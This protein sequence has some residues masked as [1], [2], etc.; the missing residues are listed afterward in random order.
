MASQIVDGQIH[1]P[2]NISAD[3]PSINLKGFQW[4]TVDEIHPTP[5]PPAPSQHADR[6]PDAPSIT[7]ETNGAT[8]GTATAATPI[9]D[10]TV[11]AGQFEL[12]PGVITAPLA[13]FPL[14]HFQGVYA[15]NGFNTIFR[16]Q[17]GE[18]LGD[19][20]LQLNLTTEQ[21]TFGATIGSIPNRGLFG[22]PDITLQGLPYLQTIQDVT[23]EKTGKGDSITR[24][25]I[26]FETGVWLHVPGSRDTNNASSVVRMASI[27][28]GSTINAQSLA[29]S[30]SDQGTS[31]GLT[32][33]RPSF[34]TVNIT[35]FGGPDPKAPG[36]LQV[37]PSQTAGNS[38]TNRIPQDLGLFI[39][40]GTITDEILQ[41]PNKILETA[42]TGLNI[43]EFVTFEVSTGS[44]LNGGGTANVSFLQANANVPLVK[45]RFWI[46][47]I[48]YAVNIPAFTKPNPVTLRPT[49][50]A[51]STAP[52]PQF[53]ITPP[54]KLPSQ[55]TTILVPGTQIQY[56]QV[57]NL[58]F[59]GLTWPHASVAT[60]VPQAPQ[61]FT[62]R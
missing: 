23:N 47:T 56:S 50:P 48:L 60:L 46:E 53:L 3:A 32:P 42:N 10:N 41:N 51:G 8:N 44:T 20:L 14:N 18:A 38:T 7:A 54:A 57:V 11:K 4:G 33:G 45:A 28:H 15:G 31:G 16:P 59:G 6:P 52:T 1:Q 19:N 27:P 36:A 35:P 43:T 24:T 49:M 22:Q 5:P 17:T 21:L 25:D 39:K 12:H 9:P 34:E 30:I 26:H 40:Q 13:P 61:P 55:A 29:P 62:M 37:F 2:L 58:V